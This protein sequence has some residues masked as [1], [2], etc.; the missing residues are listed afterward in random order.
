MTFLKQILGYSILLL[1]C[2]SC[3]SH[4]PPKHSFEY[5]S[6]SLQPDY[7]Q[8]YAWSCLPE[9]DDF[10]DVTPPGTTAEAQASASVDVFFIHPT[11]FMGGLAWNA[12]VLDRELNAKTDERAIKHQASVFNHSCRVFAPRYRQMAMG[13]FFT[14]DTASK[15]KALNFAY[16]DVK[17]AFETYLK[18]HNQGR[19]IVIASH[20]QG[21]VHGIRLVKEFFDN[22]PLQEQL[23]AAYLAG[24]PFPAD[25]FS[26]LPVCESPDQTGCVMGWATWKAGAIPDDLDT[27][28]KDAVTVN[29]LTWRTDET[30]APDSLHQGFLM[31]NYKKIKSQHI[32]AQVHKGILWISKPFPVT[33]IKNLHIGDYN[34]FWVDIRENVQLRSQ[35]FLQGK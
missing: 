31:G 1:A 26:T 11:T 6:P 5:Y 32:N 18:D 30:L 14:E 12:N 9:K 3:A 28:Y 21:S 23:V 25:T 29:P 13:G 27:Y 20:S 35:I 7:T 8:A 2:V 33:P 22:Q 19:P 24:W 34:L 4:K 10:A 16:Q 15:A 17:K